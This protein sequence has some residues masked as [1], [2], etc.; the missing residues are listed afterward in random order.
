MYINVT[1]PIFYKNLVVMLLQYF[2]ESFSK[3]NEIV[4]NIKVILRNIKIKTLF[5]YRL[6]NI[7]K[8]ILIASVRCH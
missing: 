6:A 1:F 2:F 7:M 8:Q 3:I 4:G 5:L